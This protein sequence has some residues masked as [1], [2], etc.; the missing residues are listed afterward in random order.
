MTVFTRRDLLAL[1]L[2]GLTQLSNAGLVKRSVRDL[3]NGQGPQIVEESDGCIVATYADGTVTRLPAGRS[4]TEAHCTCPAGGLCRHRVALVLAYQQVAGTAAEAKET[5]SAEVVAW[6]PA[7]IPP[8]AVEVMLVPS[9]RNEMQRLL[10][11]SLEVRLVRGV[12][13]TASLPMATVRFL[14]PHDLAYARCDCVAGQRCAHVAL[15]VEAFRAGQVEQAQVVTLGGVHQPAGGDGME[16]LRTGIL[17]LIGRVLAEGTVGG[18]APL[19]TA[20]E[21]CRRGAE[22][23]G[24]TWIVLTLEAFEQQIS[25]YA[26]RSAR[27]DELEVL[28][29]LAELYARSHV[30]GPA[31]GVAL[32]IGE[33]LQTPMGQTRLISLGA[34]VRS[35][36]LNL[37]AS[38]LLADSD[39]G[40]VLVMEK[41][42]VPRAGETRL[43]P[44]GL[45][46]QRFTPGIQVGALAHGQILTAVARRRAD[47]LLSLGAGRGGKTALM[48]QAAILQL[49]EPLFVR[50][51]EQLLEQVREMPPALIRPRHRVR[52]VHLFDV[53]ETLGQ[54]FSA[55]DQRWEAAVG[56]AGA[57]GT[58]F[59]Q[60]GYDAGAPQA[61]GVLFAAF[62]GRHG[63]IRQIAGP[64]R[65]EAGRLVC[66]PWLVVADGVLVPDLDI[67]AETVQPPLFSGTQAS[68]GLLMPAWRWLAEAA[69]QGC[70]NLA[71]DHAQRGRQIAD[72]LTAAG[73]L[74]SADQLRA[75]AGEGGKAWS[76]AG[77]ASCAVWLL[78]LQ[79]E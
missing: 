33:A 57:G 59:L 54:A 6:D 79:D 68:D 4:P 60:R 69:H 45:P 24:A 14:V 25:A 23:L 16:A 72:E 19:V 29:L 48:P 26:D 71:R 7:E 18:M 28:A 42:F 22:A 2:D 58:V 31:G 46:Q 75:L 70:R 78:S 74:E 9:T 47:G 17:D 27:H 44:A 20:V 13:P 3:E 11:Q 32:G 30:C 36:G 10:R 39:T 8:E 12:V 64:T 38:V 77:F 52:D 53:A 49:P 1:T 35:E 41:V 40:S 63:E 65:I 50:N 37:R 76:A 61:L 66:E 51:V 73:Y 67:P 55:G 62:A 56:L 43:D 5:A 15:A 21:T 34:A